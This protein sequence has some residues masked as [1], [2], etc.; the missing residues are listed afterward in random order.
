M[1]DR[2]VVAVPLHLMLQGSVEGIVEAC[3]EAQ[4][5]YNTVDHARDPRDIRRHA[6]QMQTQLELV[7]GGMEG[8]ASAWGLDPFQGPPPP[9]W[10]PTIAAIPCKLDC[11]YASVCFLF[12]S[13]VLDRNPVALL[14]IATGAIDAGQDLFTAQHNSR[15]SYGFHLMCRC[16]RL[17]CPAC[18][19]YVPQEACSDFWVQEEL[20]GK[21]RFCAYYIFESNF[22][23]HN[24]LSNPAFTGICCLAGSWTCK[25]WRRRLEQQKR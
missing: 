8:V 17:H 20:V 23:W 14:S 15:R 11:L 18:S 10:G 3:S 6:L 4:R 16:T 5:L 21:T 24:H 12:W 7:A 1:R 9:R 19:K 22:E 13:L 2:V 25:G